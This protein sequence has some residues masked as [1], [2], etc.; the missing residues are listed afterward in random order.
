MTMVDDDD[1]TTPL[2]SNSSTPTAANLENADLGISCHEYPNAGLPFN[3]QMKCLSSSYRSVGRF[4]VRKE[5]VDLYTKIWRRYGHIA[6][7]NVVQHCSSALVTTVNCLLP[8]IVE[9]EGTSIRDVTEATVEKWENMVSTCESLKFNVSWLRNRLDIVK[10]D[11]AGISLPT[12]FLLQRLFW[13]RKR[14]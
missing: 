13:N 6:T 3:I 9:M 4:L 7:R 10:I 11:R 14:I 1:L 5:F 2:P 12:S 8:I